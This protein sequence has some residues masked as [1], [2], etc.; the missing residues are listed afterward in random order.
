Y[1]RILL[2]AVAW[3]SWA[4][5]DLYEPP[6]SQLT[7]DQFYRNES[8]AVAAVNSIYTVMFGTYNAAGVL[9]NRQL[10]MYEMATDDYTAGTR[11]RS[12]EV[13]DISKLSYAPKN[14]AIERAW[15]FS[16]DAINRANIAIAKIAVIPEDK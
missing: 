10:M 8:D 6:K 9:F 14:L 15:Q 16:Y 11:T 12:A 1:L 3:L 4:C 13:I 7:S 5:A 2:P